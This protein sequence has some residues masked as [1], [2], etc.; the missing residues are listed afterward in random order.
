MVWVPTYRFC[1]MYHQKE[2]EKLTNLDYYYMFSL[3]RNLNELYGTDFTDSPVDIPVLMINF[4]DAFWNDVFSDDLK[5]D[6]LCHIVVDWDGNVITHN[7]VYYFQTLYRYSIIIL[8]AIF[9]SIILFSYVTKR[10]VG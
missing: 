6:S 10:L 2:F 9:I 8:L 5:Y 3:I 1:E 4:V 7:S